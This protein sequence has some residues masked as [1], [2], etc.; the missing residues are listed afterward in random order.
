MAPH[1]GDWLL[2]LPI[3]SC[4]LRLD[5]EAVRVAVGARIG[6]SLCVP[7]K[8]SCGAE[9]DA[10]IP[11]AMVCKKAPG[12]MA[13]HHALND[14]VS[15]AFISAGIPASKEPAGL[16]TQDGKRPGGLSLILWQNGKLLAWD[17][18]MASTLAESCGGGSERIWCS[19]RAAER[20]LEKIQGC[21]P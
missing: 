15:R 16:C 20:K 6:L 10:E 13:R 2:A 19:G 18:T 14:I 5:D 11:R 7:H 12:R 9:V 1:S 3:T 17:V 8:C 4:G 21:V